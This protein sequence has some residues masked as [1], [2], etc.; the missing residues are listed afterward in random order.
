MQFDK[1]GLPFFG[2]IV[3]PYNPK[4]EVTNTLFNVFNLKEESSLPK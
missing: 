4:Q 2:V 3:G 1:S